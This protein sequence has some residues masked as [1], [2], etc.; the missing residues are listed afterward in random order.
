M[1]RLV[2]LVLAALTVAAAPVDPKLYSGLKWRNVGPYRGGRVLAVAGVPG[3]PQTYYFGGVAGG[4]WKSSNGGL[5]WTPVF[6]KQDIASIGAIAVAPSDPNVVY[7]GSGEACI[8]GN[9]SYG[10]GMYKSLDAGRTWQSIGL[11]DTRAIGRVIV[12]PRNSDRV[13]VAALGHPFGPN[14][15][16]GVFRTTDGGAR[17]TKVLFVDNDTGAIDVQFDPSNANVLY[18]GL[19]QVRRL[20][21]NLS[22]GGKGS[23]LYK[24]TD[25]GTT[26]K[27]LSGNGL[28]AGIYGRI[29]L[30][31]SPVDSNRVYAS[32]EASE[33]GLF[34]SDD[35]GA[36][37]SRVN[38]DERFRQRAWY[39][40]HIFADPKSI[41]TIYALNT[42]L[43]RSIDGG[44]TFDLLP[45]PHGDHHGLWIDPTDPRRMINGNDGGATITVDG[46]KTWTQEDNQ[47]TAQFYHVITDDQFPYRIYGTQQDN[48]SV[49]LKSYGDGGV[50]DERDWFEFGG[51]TGFIA[52]DPRDPNILYGNNEH[53]IFRYDHAAAQYQ[54]ISVAPLDVSGRGA[55]ELPHRF[56]WT[57]PLV[58]PKNEPGV[59]YTAGES[60]WRSTDDGHS[61]ASISGDLTRNDKSKQV[62]S[63]GPIQLDITSVE[64]YD[65]VF[66]LA[67]SPTAKG[68]LWAGTDD[69]WVWVTRD[70]GK[71]WK[72]VTPP[73]APEWGT[74]DA[75]DPSPSS[76]GGAYVAID[77]HRMDDLKPYAWKTKDYGATWTS[78][79][80]G[81]PNGAYVHAVRE[82]PKRA[83]LL[84]AAT[85]LGVYVSF[86]DGAR[87][88]PLMNGLPVTSATDLTVHGDDVVISTN[89]RGFWVLDDV[90]PLRELAGASGSI[91]KQDAHLYAP[92]R[93]WRIYY[94]VFPDKRRPVGENGPQGA[95][96]DYWLAKEPKGDVTI[97]IFDA[98]GALVRKL[99]SAAPNRGPDQP[100]EWVDLVRTPDQL[101]K[102]MG[103]NRFA[104]D[105]RWSEPTQIPGAFYQGLP[106][107]GAFAL[108]GK[109]TVKLTV[110]GKSQTQ[111]LELVNDPRSKASDADLRASFE[112]SVKTLALIDRVHVAVD[113][114]RSTRAQLDTIKARLTDKALIAAIDDL[115]K[116]MAPIEGQLVQVKL[117]SSEGMLRFPAMLNEQL[118]SFR[119]SVEGDRPPTQ[120]QLDLYADFA[121]RVD[122]QTAAWK[123][124]VSG[125]VPVLNKKI[126]SSGIALVDPT[127]PLVPAVTSG[128]K[129]T[130][131]QDL[132]HDRF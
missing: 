75:I 36:T 76:A 74:V 122:A 80:A 104:W 24:S 118:D 54:D 115:E 107:W 78:I 37:W 10:T 114:I 124:I 8:R 109:Y 47:P 5:S 21:W 132:D 79:S 18:A 82:D 7:V 70:T 131:D 41:D 91:A 34:R 6:D 50:I 110:D 94:D 39:F 128:G 127:A 3:D 17:W 2:L 100:P 117:G 111:P 33:G 99:S 13:F 60:V 64:Y 58:A 97:E 4:V 68:T 16:R 59:L 62:P 1:R 121:K 87:W 20:P 52:P 86:D 26:W 72:K 106:P 129:A 73:G 123:A 105:L 101:D 35:A 30:A 67:E 119:S 116:K 81:L 45:A 88:Q 89:G 92:Q 125:D 53:T 25:G 112:L 56:Q 55:G 14:A 113:Q 130:A 95:V 15:E 42:G 66:A 103:M 22:S 84:Y 108:P 11:R 12:D 57:S 44:K 63:G 90:T 69:G 61:W 38:S 65:T 27:R 32:I 77:R 31:I 126:V 83:G 43:F 48:S 71:T 46:G 51:E 98:S 49:G 93:A 102:H 28:P 19:W 29:G 85:E 40:S 96:F 23:G 120:P 9:I